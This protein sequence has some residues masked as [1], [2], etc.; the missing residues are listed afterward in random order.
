MQDDIRREHA[1]A[2][3]LPLSPLPGYGTPVCAMTPKQL[4]AE[5]GR[6]SNWTNYRRE[7]LGLN[8]P[9]LFEEC[10]A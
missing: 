7:Q 2:D 9:N 8:D 1:Y 10:A 3:G 4:V 6:Q 5:L